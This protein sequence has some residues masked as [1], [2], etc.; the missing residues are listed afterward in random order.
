MHAAAGATQWNGQVAMSHSHQLQVVRGRNVLLHA[1][2]LIGL[3][4]K[5]LLTLLFVSLSDRRPVRRND[6]Q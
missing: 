4:C 1:N 3:L 2:A 5:N 6:R